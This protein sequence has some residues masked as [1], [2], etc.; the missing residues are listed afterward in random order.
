MN[1]PSSQD[2]RGQFSC[3]A[4]TQKRTNKI[5]FVSNFEKKIKAYNFQNKIFY[6]NNIYTLIFIVLKKIQKCQKY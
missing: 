6:L 4:R 5:D 3:N 2:F 1:V